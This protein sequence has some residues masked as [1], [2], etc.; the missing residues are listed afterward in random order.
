MP[1]PTA[2]NIAFAAL[3]IATV[4]AV[5]VAVLLLA[6]QNDNAPILI[7]PHRK[8]QPRLLP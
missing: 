2:R 4:A 8:P 5:L 6:R 3:V 1:E 7:I